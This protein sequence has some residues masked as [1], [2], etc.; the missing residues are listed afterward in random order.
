MYTTV[1]FVALLTNVI[2]YLKCSNVNLLPVFYCYNGSICS[3][4]L[5]V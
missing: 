2:D 4:G 1:S 3:V 5:S